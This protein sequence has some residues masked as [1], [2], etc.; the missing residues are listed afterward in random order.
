MAVALLSA[1]QLFLLINH[2][3]ILKYNNDQHS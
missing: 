3:N 1:T 2:Y